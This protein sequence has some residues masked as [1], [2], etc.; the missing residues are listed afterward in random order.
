MNFK[1]YNM[2][3]KIN[4]FLF[5][6]VF[7]SIGFAQI[8]KEQFALTTSN[9]DDANSKQLMQNTWERKTDVSIDSQVEPTTTAFSF[10]DAEKL[11][12][13]AA[14]KEKP[15]TTVKQEFIINAEVAKAWEVLGPG[16]ED[17]HVWASAIKSSSADDN[18][19]FNGSP[20]TTRN[21]SVSGVG[22]V[23]E[24][25]LAYSP[26]EH[27]L[28]Y[29]VIEGNPKPVKYMAITWKF[30]AIDDKTTKVEITVELKSA[31][32]GVVKKKVTKLYSE[33]GEEFKYYV[34]NG[35]PH[36]RKIKAVSKG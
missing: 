26:S 11:Q 17:L 25:L 9:I 2:K 31:F 13:K 3:K 19:S 29:Q 12:I 16:Y 20:C 15:V 32:K 1:F 24:K 8:D 18:Q 34:E 36:P 23:K 6:V 30:V 5:T 22:N 10:E 21:C 14:G 4:L 28:T 27:T 35:Q 33:M 7:T